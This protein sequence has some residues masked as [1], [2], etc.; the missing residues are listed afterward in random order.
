MPTLEAVASLSGKN[1]GDIMDVD[2]HYSVEKI[3]K[4]T[5]NFYNVYIKARRVDDSNPFSYMEASGSV[6]GRSL[7][8]SAG[9]ATSCQSES[10]SFTK[11]CAADGSI[12]I[13]AYIDWMTATSYSYGT[14]SN[15][16]SHRASFDLTVSPPKF[17]IT[18]YNSNG[19]I[20]ERT[21][22]NYLYNQK[23]TLISRTPTCKEPVS[24]YENFTIIGNINGGIGSNYSL[25]ATK[26]LN[27]TYKPKCWTSG[28]IEYNLGSSFT[29]QN[30]ISMTIVWNRTDAVSR[31]LNNTIAD[32]K[33]LG[34]PKK[35]STGIGI[36]KLPLKLEQSDT[37]PY[38]TIDFGEITEFTFDYW[39]D[40]SNNR[41]ADTKTFTAAATVY[42][43]YNSKYTDKRTITLPVPEK[44]DLVDHR[45][46]V[47][48]DAGKGTVD[49][50]IMYSVHGTRYTFDKWIHSTSGSVIGTNGGNMNY[51]PGTDQTTLYATWTSKYIKEN[52]DLPAAKMKD[53]TFRG[54]LLDLASDELIMSIVPEEDIVLYAKFIPTYHGEVWVF[55]KGEWKRVIP[56]LRLAN[57]FNQNIDEI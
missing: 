10:I 5:A 1:G 26:N 16:S 49:P 2:L 12:H 11:Q 8:C 54:W 37:A 56:H 50:N 14:F 30:D 31:Y 7:S 35:A 15:D 43:H 33:K 41:L 57:T 20:F 39:M 48:L 46:Q 42:A 55:T 3:D 13:S 4:W 27:Y 40:S 18:Y 6:D 51:T 44:A 19:E 22:E 25:Q 17:G 9:N 28:G 52:L 23:V 47:T 29:I 45:Y 21:G 38:T 53:C 36:K 34:T 32:L 24:G